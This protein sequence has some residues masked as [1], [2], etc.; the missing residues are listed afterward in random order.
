MNSRDTIYALPLEHVGKFT[1]D[2]QVVK[3]FPDMIARSVPGYASIL[4]MIGEL[5]ER[6]V[7]SNTN[8]YDLGCSLGAATLLMRQRI[9]RNCRIVAMD[10]SQA[11]VSAFSNVLAE[12][13]DELCPVDVLL[14]DIRD[15]V[16]QDSSFSVLNFTLQFVPQ[17]EREALISQIAKGT[18]KGGALVL[19]EKV[20]FEN[21]AHQDLMT[22]LHHN[23]KR[24]NGY[25]D[26]EIAQKRAS[27]DATLIPET[28][29]THIERLRAA[30][31][32]N[33]TCWFQCFNFVSILAVK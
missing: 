33:V 1:F 22:G 17:I 19:S 16:I 6:Y 28:L 25:S 15:A 23:F 32:S 24:A 14:S 12:S 11:M 31:F 2:E 29:E 27:L 9:P 13:D 26:L 4:A 8:V 10:T 3:C 21:Q 18:L 30:G 7:V 20:C 5:A